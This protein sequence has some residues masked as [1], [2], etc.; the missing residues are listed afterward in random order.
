MFSFSTTNSLIVA[1]VTKPVSKAAEVCYGLHCMELHQAPNQGQQEACLE[2]AV[3]ASRGSQQGWLKAAQPAK[4]KNLKINTKA[5][6][7]RP[8]GLVVA[9]V[10]EEN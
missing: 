5:G 2:G 4:P 7:K 6:G 3:T 8:V 10:Q 1:E 9:F